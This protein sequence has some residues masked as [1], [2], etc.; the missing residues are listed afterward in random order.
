MFLNIAAAA[1]VAEGAGKKD[2][3]RCN[4]DGT[5]TEAQG[6]ALM[7]AVH[8][9]QRQIRVAAPPEL[10][11]SW[12]KGFQ[13]RQEAEARAAR[14]HLDAEALKEEQK[15]EAASKAENIKQYLK[16]K[17]RPETLFDSVDARLLHLTRNGDLHAIVQS[18]TFDVAQSSTKRAALFT[19]TRAGNANVLKYLLFARCDALWQEP[20]TGSTAL[21]YAA[22]NDHGLCCKILQEAGADLKATDRAGKR[23]NDVAGPAVSATWARLGHFACETLVLDDMSESCSSSPSVLMMQQM[24]IKPVTPRL[25]ALAFSPEGP[26]VV[27]RRDTPGSLDADEDSDGT[28]SYPLSP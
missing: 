22:Q 26:P 8:E 12:N 9:T 19:A 16:L 18:D 14:R 17:A 10:P 20:T 23:P 15:R 28:A 25:G 1:L 24:T 13:R 27:S 11:H 7:M 3:Q 5:N 2:A 6:N 21:H 4:A